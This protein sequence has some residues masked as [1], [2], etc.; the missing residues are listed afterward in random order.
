MSRILSYLKDKHSDYKAN[1]A[2]EKARTEEYGFPWAKTPMEQADMAG[3]A[4]RNAA[5]QTG[6]P[7]AD[8]EARQNIA[9]TT[10][11]GVLRE[12][13]QGG[14]MDVGAMR[15][16]F[17]PS[18]AESVRQMQRMLNQA[19]Y[20]GADGQLLEEDGKFGPQTLAALRKM[21]GAHRDDYASVADLTAN[22]EARGNVNTRGKEHLAGREGRG[23]ST[24]AQPVT[25]GWAG[26]TGMFETPADY[27]INTKQREDAVG[28][29]RGG[30][31]SIDDAIEQG[32]PWLAESAPYRGAKEGIKSFFNWAG[33]AD[34]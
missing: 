7:T 13:S 4:A 25:T 19:K 30:A 14:A 11:E 10:A 9:Q 26:G 5:P 6:P 34:Y 32:A 22:P 24:V 20:K 27:D 23:D 1:R 16:G 28:N 3:Q 21:Q 33:D 17:D 2:D 8:S 29:V 18:N 15:Q 12:G 31:K